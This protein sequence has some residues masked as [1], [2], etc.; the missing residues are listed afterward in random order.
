MSPFN[1]LKQNLIFDIPVGLTLEQ[2]QVSHEVDLTF[3]FM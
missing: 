2:L 3:N 1:I